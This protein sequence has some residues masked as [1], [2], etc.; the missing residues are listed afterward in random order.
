V[1]VPF[2]VVKDSLAQHF[3]TECFSAELI[4]RPG[5]SGLPIFRVQC[6]GRTLALRSWPNSINSRTKIEHW[7]QVV[8][9]LANSALNST[10]FPK[11][12]PWNR[13]GVSML[14]QTIDGLHWTL[15]TWMNG[16]PL[17]IEKISESIVLQLS[18]RLAKLHQDTE[19]LHPYRGPSL[20]I[21]E[22]LEG[23]HTIERS[24][25]EPTCSEPTRLRCQ[26][27]LRRIRKELSHWQSFLRRESLVERPQHWIVRD[28]W[29]ENLLVDEDCQLQSIV[30]LG[31]SRIEWPAFD[32]VRL[33]GSLSPS[34][35][36]WSKAYA[37]YQAAMPNSKLPELAVCMMLH[38]I[39]TGIA[40]AHWNDR[41]SNTTLPHLLEERAL[42]RASELL[43]I[44]EG[45]EEFQVK[46]QI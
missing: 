41:L 46:F 31:A 33:V 39:S 7:H 19:R 16:S 22:R 8:T 40:I 26:T 9:L 18:E 34:A 6:N 24:R 36:Y 23:L 3:G 13:P 37:V 21:Q 35:S 20:A 10:L 27:V 42:A 5:F 32:F 11:L 4:D 45:S 14:F 28:L 38:R 43:D 17:P 30:D 15:A 25:L 29:R 2:D 12:E 44:W 1:I